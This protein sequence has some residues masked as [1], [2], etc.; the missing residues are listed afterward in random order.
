MVQVCRWRW[1]SNGD[2]QK[3]LQT[4][5]RNRDNNNEKV[6]FCLGHGPAHVVFHKPIKTR[7]YVRQ[8][9][10]Y[11]PR[12]SHELTEDLRCPSLHTKA[13]S[14]TW[15]P[16]KNS[17]LVRTPS[18][19]F[20]DSKF[21]G[22]APD[23]IL[24]CRGKSAREDGPLNR[25]LLLHQ[26]PL[27]SLY[28]NNNQRQWIMCC[29]NQDPFWCWTRQRRP[30]DGKRRMMAVGGGRAFALAFFPVIEGLDGTLTATI[31]LSFRDCF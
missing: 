26:I 10:I 22:Y 4:N 19:P 15:C 27:C 1:C 13:H 21:H 16:H 18:W 31:L 20:W 29:K 9:T 8:P 7:V 2:V 14:T 30:F 24:P 12:C 25:F 23:W 5:R 28:Y 6:F 17:N 11:V 3:A